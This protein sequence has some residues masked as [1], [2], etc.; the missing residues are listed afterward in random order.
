[1][2]QS[3]IPRHSQEVGVKRQINLPWSKALEIAYRS[4]RV[5]LGRSIIT[6][7]GVIL[8]VAFMMSILSNDTII[9]ALMERAKTD[10]D[11]SFKLQKHEGIDVTGVT[12]EEAV[13]DKR[14]EMK[15]TQIWLISLSLAV[16]FIGIVNAMLMSVTERFREIG[17]MKCLGALDSFIT[18]LF[19]LE[20]VF[21]GMLGTLIG[22]VIGLGVSL[23]WKAVRYGTEAYMS[24]DLWL[25]I[26]RHSVF[27]FFVGTLISVLAAYFPARSAARMAP[28]D[29]MRADD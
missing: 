24:G 18:R 11:I 6:M 7:V 1:M 3:D 19:F 15:Q 26:L 14:D 22:I 2:T 23:A 5:R 20:S 21:Q 28:V 9:Q 12:K 16:A 4:M 25:A 13:D 10:T 17:T 27:A 29:A 8:A